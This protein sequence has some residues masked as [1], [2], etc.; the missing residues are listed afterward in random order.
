[1]AIKR[2]RIA[3]G[4]ILM[5]SIALG[6]SIAVG[7][8]PGEVD[9]PMPPLPAG[10]YDA[11]SPASTSGGGSTVTPIPPPPVAK[12]AA[13]PPTSAQQ[14]Q[15][16]MQNAQQA[17]Q[18]SQQNM[19]QLQQQLNYDPEQE[20]RS[21]N[22]QPA[23]PQ[24]FVPSEVVQYQAPVKL[25]EPRA[26]LRTSFGDIKIKLYST[27][28]P[29]LV[30]NFIE[31][32]RGDREFVDVK[33]G[34]KDR[35]PYYENMLFH[36]VLK[37]HFIQTGCPYGTGRGGPGYTV[38]DEFNELVTFDRPGLVA[39]APRR[40]GNKIA[41]NANGSQF[42]ITLSPKPEW[43][44]QISIIGE[45]EVGMDVVYKIAS[46]KTGPT[47]RPFRKIYLRSVDVIDEQRPHVEANPQPASVAPPTDMNGAPIIPGQPN[48]A[49]GAPGTAPAAAP[50]A[51]APATAPSSPTY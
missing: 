35:K 18:R 48:Q 37:G 42:L 1:M 46:A 26:V 36:R 41:K 20:M 14:A 15:Q 34:K 25:T 44:G 11:A 47:D 21:Y 12:P 8:T 43:D 23:K 51:Q 6:M 13:P 22:T 17:L 16:S 50:P 3:A 40:D 39:M 2:Q 33:T 7:Q 5:G 10:D 4:F 31:L 19:R 38:E 9:L 45:V 32:A 49:V 27:K 24:P 29:N 28:A 30:K